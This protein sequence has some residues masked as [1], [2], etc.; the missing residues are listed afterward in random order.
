MKVIL[1]TRTKSYVYVFLSLGRYLCWWT[2]RS[3]RYHP[4]SSQFFGTD[5]VY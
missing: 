4:P 1:E 5:M 2:I 3:A